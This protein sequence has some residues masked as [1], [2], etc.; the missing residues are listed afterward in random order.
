VIPRFINPDPMPQSISVWGEWSYIGTALSTVSSDFNFMRVK[1]NDIYDP[2]LALTTNSVDT[3]LGYLT[4]YGNYVVTQ[5]SIKVDIVNTDV[6][7]PLR[8]TVVPSMDDPTV[9]PLWT[10]DGPILQAPYAKSVIVGN[11][12][13]FDKGSISMTVDI[14]K[15][16]GIGKI[17]PANY[18]YTGNT[19]GNSTGQAGPLSTG[20]WVISA[21]AVTSSTDNLDLVVSVRTCYHVMFYN[22]MA[23]NRSDVSAVSL[24]NKDVEQLDSVARVKHYASMSQPRKP[25]TSGL[26]KA[27]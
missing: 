8:L 12:N 11:A 1:L 2:G 25:T 14:G 23:P 9:S 16:S 19:Q 26:K 13:G 5:S 18:E 6:D 10:T 3:I 24:V 22:A 27:K 21:Q 20:A 17:T 7:V 4:R 15:L